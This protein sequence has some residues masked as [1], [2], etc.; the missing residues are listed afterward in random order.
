MEVVRVRR[1]EWGIRWPSGLTVGGFTS[2]AAAERN[3]RETAALQ[4]VMRRR[5]ELVDLLVPSPASGDEV[6]AAID[7]GG[8]GPLEQLAAQYGLLKP[9]TQGAA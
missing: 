1:G 7:A 3:L 6:I 5:S 9:G 2:R 8:V 4:A